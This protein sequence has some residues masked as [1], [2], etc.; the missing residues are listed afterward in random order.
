MR[1]A[2]CAG[3]TDAGAENVH[4]FAPEGQRLVL[5]SSRLDAHYCSAK[6]LS[7]RKNSGSAELI[8]DDVKTREGQSE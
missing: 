2:S 4:Q 6:Y 3:D 1:A 5:R 8:L 7:R